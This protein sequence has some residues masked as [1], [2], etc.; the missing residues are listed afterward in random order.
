[1]SNIKLIHEDTVLP[2][3]RPYDWDVMINGVPYYVVRI[4]GYVHSIGGHYGEND[5]WAYP[6]NQI[7]TYEN[8]I[9]FNCC[10]PVSW[11]IR[12]ESNNR[13]K[14]KWGE[15]EANTLGHAVITRNGKDF[16]SISGGIDNA[17]DKARS[18]IIEFEEHPLN[19]DMIDY[20]KKMIG[21]K[22]WW[23]SE[24]AIIESWVYGQ[25][26]VILKPDGI[27]GFTVPPEFRDASLSLLYFNED[28]T[29]KADI[30]DKRIWWFRH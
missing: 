10:C 11:G 24:P 20:D 21:R 27:E 14:T 16:Y 6:R 17:I 5:L 3:L 22:V 15:T 13:N 19:L 28:D 23:R 25:A 8:L 26:C 1:M 12:F 29:I 4:P 30:L 9:E 7:P 18:A 2:K